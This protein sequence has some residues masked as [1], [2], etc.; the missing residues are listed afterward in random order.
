MNASAL[1]FTPL[2]EYT[3]TPAVSKVVRSG[4][5]NDE[6][7]EELFIFFLIEKGFSW[8]MFCLVFY[9]ISIIKK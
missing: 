6:E 1:K 8:R 4:Q 9:D 5:D 2:K 7:E 3:A